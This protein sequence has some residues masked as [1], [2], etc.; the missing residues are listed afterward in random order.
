MK[1]KFPWEPQNSL[2]RAIDRAADKYGEGRVAAFAVVLAV[3]GIVVAL[4]A[5]HVFASTQEARAFNRLT[6]AHATTWDAMWTE[7]R[8][9]A[10]PE[11]R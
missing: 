7:L 6:G 1:K 4:C 5:A 10:P 9:Q 3:G 2:D 8:V 11:D